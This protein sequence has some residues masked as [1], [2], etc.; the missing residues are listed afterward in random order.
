MQ[1]LSNLLFFSLI[2]ISLSAQNAF[3]I[4]LL[5]KWED[6]SIPTTANN[7]VR[8]NEIWGYADESGEYAILGSTTSV[9]FIDVTNPQQPSLVDEFAGGDTTIWRDMKTYEDRAYAIADNSSEGMMIF[10][11]S[12][13]PNSVSKTYHSNEF[14]KKAHNIFIDE[15]N[16]RLYLAGSDTMLLG[17]LVFD[18]AT[19]KDQPILLS[20][21]FLEGGEYVH[22]VFVKDNIAYCSHG[23]NGFYIWDFADPENPKRIAD[24]LTFGYN[25]SSWITEDGNYALYAEELPSGV[26][27]GIFD[28]QK[29]EE[30]EIKI[31]NTFKFPQL[32]FK[33][34]RNTPHNPFILGNYAYVSYYEDGLVVFDISNPEEVFIVGYYDTRENDVY[35][36]T[37][38][39][40]GAYPFLPS[41]NLLASDTKG[42]LFVLRLGNAF[43]PAQAQNVNIY[44]NPV[45]DRLSIEMVRS[46]ATDVVLSLYETMGTLVFTKQFSFIGQYRYVW[47]LGQLPNGI[48]FLKI[49]EA[50]QTTLKKIIIQ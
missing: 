49:E 24:A 19:N 1:K 39:C 48:Y 27:L 41:G 26:P 12:D 45:A 10:D 38:G 36:G 31:I 20:T 4:D 17:M 23:N 46:K 32:T 35:L 28:L 16:G 50:G 33:D 14:F 40:W 7:R 34:D 30:G 6:E 42:G 9:H 2:C 44:P 29:M 47:E 15:P 22:D 8:Y 43:E 25:H 21:V 3:N 13:L 5:G 11:L 37:R 18:I